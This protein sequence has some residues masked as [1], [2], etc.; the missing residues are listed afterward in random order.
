MNSIS[1]TFI[2]KYLAKLHAMLEEYLEGEIGENKIMVLN[3]PNGL[4]DRKTHTFKI[5]RPETMLSSKHW[6]Y[7]HQNEL[8]HT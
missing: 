8:S 2:L 1:I 4:T 7:S 6:G 3:I 5:Q